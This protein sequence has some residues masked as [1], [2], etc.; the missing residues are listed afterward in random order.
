MWHNKKIKIIKYIVIYRH[1][2]DSCLVKIT[3]P[4]DDSLITIMITVYYFP[5]THHKW[6]GVIW[7][8]ATQS[9]DSWTYK[10]IQFLINKGI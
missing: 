3:E 7:Y 2:R 9:S 8:S 10:F 6:L 4:Q 1:H 5:V